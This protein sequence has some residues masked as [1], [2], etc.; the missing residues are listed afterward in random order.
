MCR[1]FLEDNPLED[2]EKVAVVT[3][4]KLIAALTAKGFTGT[5][6]DARIYGYAWTENAEVL[7]IETDSL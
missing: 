1:Q 6:A 7:G 5:G 4:S 2:D 3:H